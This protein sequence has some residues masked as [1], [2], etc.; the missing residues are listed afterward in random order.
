MT[1]ATI[2]Q[3]QTSQSIITVVAASLFLALASQVTIPLPFTPVPFSLQTLAV[4]L[5]GMT[6]GSKRGLA[7][8]LLYTAEVALGMPFLAGGCGGLACLLGPCGG[9]IAG[10]IVQAYLVGF[11]FEKY[12]APSR[13]IT[14]LALS[15]IGCLQLAMGSAWLAQFVGWQQTLALGFMPFIPGD[16]LK[17]MALSI[18]NKR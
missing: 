9:Y 4:M 12:P 5:I 17:I 18:F 1:T 14:M 8:L 16:M 15:G 7:A 6:L 2:T 10:F 3:S 11:F 13:F